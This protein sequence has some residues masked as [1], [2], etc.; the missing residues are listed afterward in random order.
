MCNDGY[1]YIITDAWNR[2]NYLFMEDFARFEK[3]HV[4]FPA[5]AA[6]VFDKMTDLR[7]A[8]KDFRAATEGTPGPPSPTEATLCSTPSPKN[9]VSPR[10]VVDATCS[11]CKS[12]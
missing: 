12:T 8:L 9:S 5:E 7:L 4:K 6:V 2:M 3:E 11:L 10:N 1:G